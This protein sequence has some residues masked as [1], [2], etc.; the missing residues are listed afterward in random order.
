MAETIENLTYGDDDDNQ[1]IGDNSPGV[2]HV[3]H[4]E[5][6]DD[7]LV[8][9]SGDDVL[10]GGTGNDVLVGGDGDDQLHGGA[11]DDLLYGD[12]LAQEQHPGDSDSDTFFYR[13]GGGNDWI[14]DFDDGVDR[15]DLSGVSSV[16]DMSDLTITK[17]R[18]GAK[19]SFGDEAGSINLLYFNADDLD[20][21]DFI[22]QGATDGVDGL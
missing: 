11:G 15:I 16:H 1:I 8:G 19:I 12:G 20:A 21:S 2:T 14:K 4:G 5:G 9:A 3:M 22:F 10:H 18:F 13:S 6:G 7:Y 17:E